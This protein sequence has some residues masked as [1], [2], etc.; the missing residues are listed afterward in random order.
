MARPLHEI[1]ATTDADMF[2]VTEF[3]TWGVPTD[4]KPE[5]GPDRGWPCWDAMYQGKHDRG[6]LRR[7]RY[8]QGHCTSAN[9]SLGQVLS[10]EVVGKKE[11]RLVGG[12]GTW[13]CELQNGAAPMCTNQ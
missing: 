10:G 9:F 11:F 7:Y 4:D 8:D 1:I 5:C 12:G 2:V 3:N 6:L 13:T